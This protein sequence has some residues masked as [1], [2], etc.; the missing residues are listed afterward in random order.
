RTAGR[1]WR[2]G[3]A[4][5]CRC[6]QG[7]RVDPRLRSGWPVQRLCRDFAAK[8]S[9]C[10]RELNAP[11]SRWR[12]VSTQTQGERL[13]ENSYGGGDAESGGD[14]ST[15]LLSNA[16]LMFERMPCACLITDSHFRIVDWNA[17]A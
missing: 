15:L 16:R 17:A 14:A 12:P 9:G 2:A 4:T 13:S 8:A 7:G 6:R 10:I 1:H 5:E 3:A 11:R